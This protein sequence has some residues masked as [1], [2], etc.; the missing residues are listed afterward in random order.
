MNMSRRSSAIRSE[1]LGDFSETDLNKLQLQRRRTDATNR[2]NTQKVQGL[3]NRDK[4]EIQRLKNEHEE[5]LGR[6]GVSMADTSVVQDVTAT[7]ACGDRVDEEMKAEKGKLTFLKEQILKWERKLAAQRM[8]GGATRCKSDNS[9]LQKKT[10]RIENKLLRGQKCFSELMIRNAQLRKELEILQ[11]EKKQFL[12]IQSQMNKELHAIRR[13]IRNLTTK[14]TEALNASVKNQEKQRLLTVQNTKDVAQYDKENISLELEMAHYCNFEAFLQTKAS[15]RINEDIDYSKDEKCKQLWSMEWKLEDFEDAIKMI[16][17]GTQKS[18]L[19]Q[20]V[21]NFIQMEGQNYT[22]LNFVNYQHNE[23]EAIRRQISQLCSEMEAF[24]VEKKKQQEQHQA[25]ELGI[26]IKQEATEQQLAFYQ[27][28]VELLEKVLNQL[29]EG[30]ES[31]LQF[32]CDLLGSSDEVKAK[33]IAEYL[34]IVE[35]RVNE[36]LTLQSYLHFQE[37]Q[38]QLDID[39]LSTIAQYQHHLEI[40]PPSANLITAAATL[41]PDDPDSLA[42]ELLEAK[43]PMFREELLALVNK[44]IQQKQNSLI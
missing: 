25:L 33:N 43:D 18:D 23:A 30:V 31:M 2:A 22:L 20:L 42:S 5:L 9:S 6:L 35:N 15:A 39:S 38:S 4:Q 8:S 19:D 3:I 7:L 13:E 29:K 14:C 17:T 1:I 21:K 36:L 40:S 11:I 26:S 24:V 12:H 34:K 16:L 37:H 27:Q 41:A 32:T 10:C 44:R 28:R